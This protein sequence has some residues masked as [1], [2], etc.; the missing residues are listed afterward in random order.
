MARLGAGAGP[1]C[2]ARRPPAMKVVVTAEYHYVATPDG[3]LVDG[4]CDYAY[5]A[6]LLEVFDEVGVFSRLAPHSPSGRRYVA[7]P[8]IR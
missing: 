6:Q 2:Y 8:R 1:R 4:K 3:V 5:W 7:S